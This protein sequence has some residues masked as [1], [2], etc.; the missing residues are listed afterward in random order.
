MNDAGW[1]TSVGSQKRRS[2]R[3]T[4][5]PWYHARQLTDAERESF[6]LTT[7][8]AQDAKRR[9]ENGEC[10]Q[11]KHPVNVPRLDPLKLMPKKRGNGLRTLS[12]FSGGGGMDLG[13]DRAGYLHIASYEILSVAGDTLRRARPSWTVHSGSDGD[14]KQ[15]DWRAYRGKVDVLHGGPPCQPFSQAGRRNGAADERDLIPELVRAV[16]LSEPPVFVCEN[17]T[18]LATKRFSEYIQKNIYEPLSSTYEISMFTLEA[19][20]FGVPQKRRR[21]FFVGFRNKNAALSFHPPK[22]T[23]SAAH[24]D[25]GGTPAGLKPTMGTRE[26][27]GLADIGIDG[28]AP[29]IR[30]GFT[31]PR[32]TTSVLNSVSAQRAWEALQIWPNGVALD[33]DRASQYVTKNGHFRLSVPDCLVLQGFPA[34]WPV[35]QTVYAA[36]GLIGNS[37]APPMAYHLAASIQVALSKASS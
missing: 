37:V 29:T 15:V 26:A 2:A 17:V 36:L 21:V 27:L 14:V 33:R 11:P 22:P 24:L 31:G 5:A 28:L 8:A 6:R 18:G 3:G 30:S 19:A 23:Y 10:V 35:G 25:G 12:L 1:T 32:H 9:A 34:D 7:L 16:K 20:D 13:F 4:D